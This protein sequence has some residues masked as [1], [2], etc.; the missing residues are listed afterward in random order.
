MKSLAPPRAHARV[1]RVL[2]AAA[3]LLTVVPLTSPASADEK[4]AC[5]AASEKAQQLRSAGKL[6]DVLA[7]AEHLEAARGQLAASA[8]VHTQRLPAALTVAIAHLAVG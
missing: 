1:G 7:D 4:Q 3:T 8:I 6:G 5:V 2:L